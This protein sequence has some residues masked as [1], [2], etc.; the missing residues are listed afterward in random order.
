VFAL[1]GDLENGIGEEWIDSGGNLFL[2]IGAPPTV[3]QARY[4]AERHADGYHFT[5]ILGF[6]HDV[7]AQNDATNSGG[8]TSGNTFLRV[9]FPGPPGWGTGP[10][11]TWD[12]AFA[13]GDDWTDAATVSGG[14]GILRIH[15]SPNAKVSFAEV[16]SSVTFF[17]SPVTMSWGTKISSVG[18]PVTPYYDGVNFSGPTFSGPT[19]YP[20]NDTIAFNELTAT[21]GVDWTQKVWFKMAETDSGSYLS[22][23]QDGTDEPADWMLVSTATLA[24]GDSD[25][26]N[27]QLDANGNYTEERTLYV[28]PKCYS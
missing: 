16:S 11:I 13:E 1:A 2:D 12:E 14:T 28:Y 15:N 18:S 17:D 26:P 21:G 27:F 8:I 5:D 22:W 23:W 4:S 3:I 20:D 25:S 19:I 10:C 9:F 24:L 6:D 7:W